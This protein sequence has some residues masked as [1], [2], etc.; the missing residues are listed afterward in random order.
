M[1]LSGFP[2]CLVIC[3]GPLSPS[4]FVFLLSF[5]LVSRRR[6]LCPSVRCVLHPFFTHSPNDQTKHAPPH[7]P[8]RPPAFHPTPLPAAC[9]A[10][11]TENELS[12]ALWTGCSSSPAL[13]GC[14]LKITGS[15]LYFYFA[16]FHFLPMTK[17]VFIYK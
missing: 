6:G 16:F 11:H 1:F 5:S 3:R 14:W 4:H 13:R 10:E 9:A 15:H 8:S 17:L 2:C 7:H 12:S